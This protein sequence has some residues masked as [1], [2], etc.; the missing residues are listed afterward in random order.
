MLRMGS[1]KRCSVLSFLAMSLDSRTGVVGW[2]QTALQLLLLFKPL[3]RPIGLRHN[4][5]FSLLPVRAPPSA[6]CKV[7]CSGCVQLLVQQHGAC[8]GAGR[9]E[10]AAA[11]TI[12][13]TS[14]HCSVMLVSAAVGSV[15]MRPSRSHFH[16]ACPAPKQDLHCCGAACRQQ[17][18][19]TSWASKGT[20]AS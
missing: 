7:H 15:L 20:T 10:A 5:R 9:T 13:A 8:N 1:A 12:F 11:T 16:S 17:V 2:A 18:W 14:R 19:L 4:L 6:V 3:Q